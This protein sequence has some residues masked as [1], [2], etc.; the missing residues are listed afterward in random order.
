MNLP[1]LKQNNRAA[2]KRRWTAHREARYQRLIYR[3]FSAGP[4]FM[5]SIEYPVAGRLLAASK[6][7]AR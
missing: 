5:I 4:T 7:R 1:R 6:V 3:R 2:K